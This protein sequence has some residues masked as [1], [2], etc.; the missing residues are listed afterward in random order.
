MPLKGQVCVPTR[1]GQ[2]VQNDGHTNRII[3]TK[4]ILPNIAG[5]NVNVYMSIASVAASCEILFTLYQFLQVMLLAS[6]AHPSSILTLMRACPKPNLKPLSQR[7][8][9]VV[10]CN[11]GQRCPFDST[12]T[13]LLNYPIN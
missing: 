5:K 10:M 1:I 13:Q 8:S 9:T 12:D 4:R 11:T 7:M 2:I 6:L 3:L